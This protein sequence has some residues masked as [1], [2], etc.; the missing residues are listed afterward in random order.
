MVTALKIVVA[1]LPLALSWAW[2]PVKKKSRTTT[3]STRLPSVSEAGKE[4]SEQPKEEPRL[5]SLDWLPRVMRGAC[6]M[7]LHSTSPPPTHNN[8]VVKSMKRGNS[9]GTF[10]VIF[11]IKIQKNGL[12][13]SSFREF[14]RNTF[15]YFKKIF[16]ICILYLKR[17]LKKAVSRNFLHFPFPLFLYCSFPFLPLCSLLSTFSLLSLNIFSTVSTY[18]PSIPDPVHYR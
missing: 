5:E 14:Q 2:I 17:F 1:Y 9:S 3:L 10:A 16:C 8:S 18:N 15:L 13:L 4:P 7:L 11:L 6:R 12:F